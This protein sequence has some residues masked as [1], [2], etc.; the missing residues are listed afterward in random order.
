[1]AAD[2]VLGG[3]VSYNTAEKLGWYDMDSKGELTFRWVDE[4][5]SARSYPMVFG[6][7]RDGLVCGVSSLLA[8]RILYNYDYVE[9]DPATG[10]YLAKNPV[11]VRNDDGTA[12]YLNYYHT[13]A[14]DPVSDRVYGYGYNAAGDAFVFK[15]S[16]YD[17]TD[18][19]IIRVVADSEY[20]ASLTWNQDE[21]RLVGFNRVSFVYIDPATGVQTE[22]YKEP[23]ADYQYSYT[24]LVYDPRERGYYWNYFTKDNVSHMALVDLTAK[25]IK[26][27]RTFPQSLFPASLQGQ[28]RQCPYRQAGLEADVRRRS[29]SLRR[30]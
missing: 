2:A 16:A 7:E 22:V 1:M 3:Y 17:M 6:W 25:T 5:A 10:E 29:G 11:S 12:N 21:Q 20:C 27:V 30:G 28:Q 24:G 8:D 14:Y 23:V 4:L 9:I 13:A 26:E 19:K 15:S 18:T